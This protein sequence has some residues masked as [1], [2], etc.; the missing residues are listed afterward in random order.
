MFN[1][2]DISSF[3]RPKQQILNQLYAKNLLHLTS[4]SAV[5]IWSSAKSNSL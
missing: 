4:V 2:E 1:L 5:I 3:V